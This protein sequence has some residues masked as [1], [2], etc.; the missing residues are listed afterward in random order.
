[1]TKKQMAKDAERIGS[2]EKGENVPRSL[3]NFCQFAQIKHFFPNGKRKN[4][5]VEK[6]IQEKVAVVDFV[7]LPTY[8]LEQCAVASLA[9][10]LLGND[11][12]K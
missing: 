5:A 1:M 10:T 6:I 4:A 12:L 11:Y 3:M 8:S 9:K 7:A 2:V